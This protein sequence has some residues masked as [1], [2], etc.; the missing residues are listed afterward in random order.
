[1]SR[2][3]QQ[4]IGD[5]EKGLIEMLLKPVEIY[6]EKAGK[7]ITVRSASMEDIGGILDIKRDVTANSPYSFYTEDE[8]PS[9]NKQMD[10]VLELS[11]GG[12]SGLIVALVDK[13]V[14]G[15][16]NFKA[17]DR[18]SRTR[19]RARIGVEFLDSYT[20][21]GYGTVL[22][23][24]VLDI[25][26]NLGFEQVELETVTINKRAVNMYLKSGFEIAGEIRKAIR[27][28]DETYLDTYLMI[29]DFK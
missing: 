11:G 26:E 28:N 6:C 10:T 7:T 13:T 14:I 12:S 23:N 2:C 5:K 27:L 20:S 17:L 1:M 9:Y 8:V 3:S 29:K 21:K 18:T 25:I 4:L 19:H 24:T 22:F 15:F 16:C